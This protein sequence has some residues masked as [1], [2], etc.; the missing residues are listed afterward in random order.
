M[1][2][3]TNW[4]TKMKYLEIYNSKI[5]FRYKNRRKVDICNSMD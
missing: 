1:F 5:L 3:Y 4:N 2:I